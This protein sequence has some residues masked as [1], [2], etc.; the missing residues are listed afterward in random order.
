MKQWIRKAGVALCGALAMVMTPAPADAAPVN[1]GDEYVA[2]GD[3]FASVGALTKPQALTHPMCGK[4]A[5]N[6]PHALAAKLNLNL[7][8]VTCGFA[9][10]IDYWAPQVWP[11]PGMALQGQRAALGPNTK[12]VTL[13]LG[14]NDSGTTAIG[15]CAAKWATGIGDCRST[16]GA[17]SDAMFNNRINYAGKDV[18]GRLNDIVADIRVQAPNAQ[19]VVTGY[20][21]IFRTDMRCLENG[22]L[23]Q[24]DLEYIQNDFVGRLNGIAQR[25]AANNGAIY[26]PAPDDL[27]SCGPVGDRN[28][29]F[30]GVFDNALPFHPTEKGQAAMADAI[31]AAL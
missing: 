12:L 17:A 13:T 27:L 3:S 11:V 9:R 6:Y 21:N 30:T 2:L 29:T 23:S 1:P 31:A 10:T 4:S 22:F 24:D 8:D 20:Y 15:P 7:T 28:A 26:V 18:E 19:V 25:V 16:M 14:G 5:V